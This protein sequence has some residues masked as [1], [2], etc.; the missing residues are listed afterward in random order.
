MTSAT[1]AADY[2]V[3]PR[4][5]YEQSRPEMLPFV[6]A[7]CRMALDVGCSNGSFGSLLR[8]ERHCSVWGIEPFES[9]ANAAAGR[10]DKVIHGAFDD[11]APLPRANF[12]CVIFN[13]VLEH[14]LNPEAALQLARQLLKPDGAVVASI[15]NIRHFPT[16]W[17]LAIHGAWEYRDCGTLDKTHLRFFTR[18]SIGAL[19]ATA[20]FEVEQVVGIYPYRGIPNA[21]TRVWRLFRLANALSGSRF[22]DMKFERFAVVAR[23]MPSA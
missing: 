9:A 18:S 15:P 19:F 21:S 4:L 20:G 5:Y 6:P 14:L 1:I 11:Q 12:D 13:D 7:S 22:D 2:H 16:V 23:P 17:H 10:L 3:K 8:R